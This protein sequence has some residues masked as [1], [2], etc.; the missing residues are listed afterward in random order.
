[1]MASLLCMHIRN[2]TYKVVPCLV[3]FLLVVALTVAAVYSWEIQQPVP[4]K[5]VVLGAILFSILV[6][7]DG[8]G[9]ITLYFLKPRVL[10]AQGES[11]DDIEHHAGASAGAGAMHIPMAEVTLPPP[12]HVRTGDVEHNT[13]GNWNPPR[14]TGK[15]EQPALLPANQPPQMQEPWKPAVDQA[16]PQLGQSTVIGR[17]MWPG[18][19]QPMNP[20]LAVRPG[21][22]QEQTR[23]PRGPRP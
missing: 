9:L 15:R 21:M 10:K 17:P 3:G 5:Y 22:A 8:C 1:M 2:I 12:P 13:F 7:V 4:T 19:L 11:G 16:L 20:Q 14:D 23:R 6:F 18:L